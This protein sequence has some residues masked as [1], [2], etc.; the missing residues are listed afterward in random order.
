MWAQGKLQR[1]AFFAEWISS[2]SKPNLR[3][4]MRA[5]CPTV[6]KIIWHSWGRATSWIQQHHV[7]AGRYFNGKASSVTPKP[8]WWILLAAAKSLMYWEINV[9]NILHHEHTIRLESPTPFVGGSSTFLQE[10]AVDLLQF[11]DDQEVV[12]QQAH[13]SKIYVVRETFVIELIDDCSLP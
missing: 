9:S 3:A 10:G 7:R 11:S 13:D 6:S 12:R 1:P 4:E 8:S 2:T 5:K